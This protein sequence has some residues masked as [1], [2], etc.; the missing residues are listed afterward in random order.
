M[1]GI[2]Q[3]SQGWYCTEITTMVLSGSILDSVIKKWPDVNWYYLKMSWIILCIMSYVRCA[4]KLLEWYNLGSV[5]DG[6]VFYLLEWY[7]LEVSRMELCKKYLK[8]TL[9]KCLGQ[10]YA[11]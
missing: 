10:Y 11:E 7:Y 5:V 1:L 6:A 2:T 3:K 9:W 4:Q 8:G